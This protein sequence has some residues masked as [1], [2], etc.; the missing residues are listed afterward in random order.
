MLTKDIGHRLVLFPIQYA[1]VWSMYKKAQSAFWTAEEI[2]LSKDM[3]D[4]LKLSENERAFVKSVLAFFAASDSIVN[5]NLAVRFMNEIDIQEVKA[6]YGFQ[7]AMENVHCVSADTFV[8]TDEGHIKIRSL[9]GKMVNVWNGEAWSLVTVMK[10]SDE[11][12]ACKVV[13]SNGVEIVCTPNHE[14]I[15]EDGITRKKTDDLTIGDTLVTPT[16]PVDLSIPDK[17]IFSHVEEHGRLAF[18]ARDEPYHPLKFNC[19]PRDYVPMNYNRDTQEAWLKGAGLDNTGTLVHENVDM[20]TSVQLM[21]ASMGKHATLEGNTLTLVSAAPLRVTH[22][23]VSPVR[24]PMYCFEEPKQ[25]RG[26]FNGVITGQSETYSL[27]LDTYIKDPA[28]K[29][30]LL[31]AVETVPSIRKK[32]DWAMKWIK[33][34]ESSFAKR[35]VAFACVEGIFFSGAFCAIFWLKERGVMP[36]LCLSNEFISR[37]ESLHTEFAIHL[38]SLLPAHE[39]ADAESVQQIVTE[40][41]AIEIEFINESISC[42]MLGMNADLMSTYIKFV[43]DRLMVQLDQEKVW[44]ANNP[45]P[46]MERISLSQKSNFF[47]HTRQSDYAKTQSAQQ[48]SLDEDF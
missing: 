24:M 42:E 18:L 37:D 28:E 6:F 13:L 25:H 38:H 12:D 43:A 15:M 23:A 44:H 16:Y 41:V 32:A 14:W 31:T 19:R 27:L 8:L 48:F 3:D 30:Q 35:L 47:E 29:T 21:L 20:L 22:L 5:E 7:I 1:S 9:E 26:C 11:A 36:G 40:A 39:K 45:F 46:F 17:L 34:A 33:D 10:T 4:W 2:D